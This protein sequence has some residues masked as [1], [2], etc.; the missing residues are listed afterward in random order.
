LEG[1]KRGNGQPSSARKKDRDA[2]REKTDGEGRWKVGGE[3]TAR[4]EG[5][6][7]VSEA[8][9]AG[10]WEGWVDVPADQPDT[11]TG[12]GNVLVLSSGDADADT[13]TPAH[14]QPTLGRLPRSSLLKKS[15]QSLVETET[16][17][18]GRGKESSKQKGKRRREESSSSED[19]GWPP[20][21]TKGKRKAKERREGTESLRGGAKKKT[22]K[23]ISG[24][25]I[26]LTP[27]P[28]SLTRP[29][30]ADDGSD[31][32]IDDNGKP[33]PANPAEQLANY[34]KGPLLSFCLC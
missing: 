10:D 20:K 19:H 15:Q 34:L 5:L 3:R 8:G 16:S 22:G 30:L 32:E 4:T 27:S 25:S 26:P 28:S 12:E 11:N 2:G 13:A 7:L 21:D 23:E 31:L 17:A 6:M 29:Q 14:C 33:F 18:T 24:S 1:A 9:D